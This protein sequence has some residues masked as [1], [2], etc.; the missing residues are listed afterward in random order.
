MGKE[1]AKVWRCILCDFIYDESK[2]IP[3]HGIAPGTSWEDVP[4]DWSCPDCGATK[5]DFDMHEVRFAAFA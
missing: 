3:E 2:G 4:E 1:N 5:A